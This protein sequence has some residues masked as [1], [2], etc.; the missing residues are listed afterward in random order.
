[1]TSRVPRSFDRRGFLAGSVALAG[2]AGI[3]ALVSACGGPSGPTASASGRQLQDV[4][5]S[6]GW[7]ENVEYA[8]LWLADSNGYFTAEGI[9]PAIQPGGPSAPDPTVVVAAGRA[10]IGDTSAL[11]ALVEAVTKGND[12]VIIGATYQNR[13]GCVISLPGYP[14]LKPKDLVG[15]KFL[16][17][18]G[19]QTYVDAVLTLAG[20]PRTYQFV[21]VGQSPEPLLQHQGDAYSGLVTNQ[22][23]ALELQG[24]KEGKDFFVTLWSDLG[25]PAYSDIFFTTRAYLNANRKS[26]VAF[27]KAVVMG[28]EENEKIAPSK[29]AALAVSDYGSSLGLSQ[30]QQTLQNQLQIPF[31]KSADTAAHGLLWV[32]PDTLGG[33]MYRA[34]G[35]FG[36]THL[37]PAASIV[38]TSILTDVY[39]GK[40]SVKV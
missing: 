33:G 34:L 29:A 11:S 36:L 16:G 18:Q 14:V 12:F 24:M 15:V 38:D 25:L 20:L 8:G 9:N 2:T 17:Q 31:T 39:Q 13:P 40:T 32:D 30:A 28:W 27:M 19:M 3:G 26:V 5:L 23:A 22:V 37:P 21:P 35:A 10:D 4:S 1:M 6:L 7:I